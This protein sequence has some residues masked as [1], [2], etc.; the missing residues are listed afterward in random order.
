M[1]ESIIY[2]ADKAELV[3]QGLWTVDKVANIQAA[4]DTLLSQPGEKVTINTEAISKMDSA[5][6]LVF[7]QLQEKLEQ[8]GK[9]VTTQAL[10]RDFNDLL[11]LIKAK[12]LNQTPKPKK[13]CD[14][15][16]LAVLG[17][18]TSQKLL[19]CLHFLGFLGH[20]VLIFFSALRK[21]HTIKWRA[22]LSILDS[23]GYRALPIVA[24][25]S[26]LIG[27]VMT[28]QIALQLSTYGA[29]IYVVDLTGM[30]IFREFG[31]LITAIIAAGRTSTAFAAQIGTMKV[32]EEIDALKTMGVSAFARIV[33]PKVLGLLIALPL[34]VVWADVFGVLGAMVM[35]KVQLGI[36]H[37][38]F[39]ERFEHVVAIQQYLTGLVKVPFFAL[40]VTLVGCYQGLQVGHSADSVGDKTTKSAVQ[41]IFL[42][43][44]VD[45][46]F[47]VIFS[48]RGV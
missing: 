44:I 39:L 24:L 30:I 33:L 15:G 35:S 25:L 14:N 6:A 31:P 46:L 42:I 1:P 16:A 4:L 28:Y 38:S 10:S 13:T 47:S 12:A 17:N 9:S 18:V 32:N 22:V 45:A 7:L 5:G 8:L 11:S 36:G 19:E 20:F 40:V 41:S 26:F 2:H 27:I 34:L 48:L 21:A 23:A 3:C 29:N 37:L 43:I